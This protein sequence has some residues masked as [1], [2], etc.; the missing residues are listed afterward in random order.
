MWNNPP[1]AVAEIIPIYHKYL[2]SFVIFGNPETRCYV[3]GPVFPVYNPEG[4]SL[5]IEYVK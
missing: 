1:H 2:S 3:R 5:S 4:Y